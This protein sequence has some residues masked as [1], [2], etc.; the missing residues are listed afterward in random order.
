MDA[1][2]FHFVGGLAEKNRMDFYEAARFQYAAARLSVKLD[3]FRRT[4]R[5]SSRV[6]S[7]S[8]TDIDLFPYERG[9]FSLKIS[10][11]VENQ[12]EYHV[13]V[14]LSTLWTYVL[15]RVFQPT[16]ASAAFDLIDDT[17][18]RSEFFQLVDKSTFETSAAINLLKSKISESHKLSPREDE[19]LDRLVA[20]AERRAYL[21]SHREILSQISPEEDASLVTMASPLLQELAVPLRRSAKLVTISA[22]DN[23]GRRPVLTV[24]RKTV[25]DL[26]S[27]QIDK[28]VTTID[29]NIVQYN[30]ESGWGKFRNDYWD[31]IKSFSVPA[32]RKGDL[33][34]N[35]LHAMREDTV[36][37]DAYFVRNLAGEPI[38]LIVV[39]IN[40]IDELSRI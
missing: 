13:S 18:L 7:A 3:Q 22:I 10:A 25:A 5:F 29:V 16:E 2:D 12:S 9:S 34:Y 33:K 39:N 23:L 17:A 31:G 19:L 27:I 32:D 11:E 21:S 35:L 24:D 37:V 30:K 26:E 6:T 20:E 4:G 8:K 28:R 14:P 1:L 15:E 40:T 36:S 38:R